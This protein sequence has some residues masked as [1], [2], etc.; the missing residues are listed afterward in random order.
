MDRQKYVHDAEGS[1]LFHSSGLAKVQSGNRIGSISRL[2]YSQRRQI[3]SDRKIIYNYQRSTIG[4]SYSELRAKSSTTSEVVGMLNKVHRQE[5][6]A[7]NNSN[8]NPYS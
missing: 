1:A 8:Y 3:D 2:S 6:N 7:R 5:F 4:G